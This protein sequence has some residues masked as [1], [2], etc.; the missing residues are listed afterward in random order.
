AWFAS[1]MRRLDAHY[2]SDGDD[3]AGVAYLSSHPRSADRI[4]AAEAAGAAFITAHPELVRE[5]PGYDPCVA[6]G[7]CPDEDDCDDDAC[8]DSD[9]ADEYEDSEDAVDSGS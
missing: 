5:T 4:A 9:E 1:A 3:D 7:I 2:D 8:I 6:E